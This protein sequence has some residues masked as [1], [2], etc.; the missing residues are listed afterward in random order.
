MKK[1]ELL[2]KNP[3]WFLSFFVVYYTSRRTW[4]MDTGAM[5][6]IDSMGK[7]RNTSSRIASLAAASKSS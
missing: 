2:D 7:Y 5:K 4:S 1:S 6:M 3:V